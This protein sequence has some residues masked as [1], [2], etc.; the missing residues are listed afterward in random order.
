MPARCRTG[1]CGRLQLAAR[2][3]CNRKA[4]LATP[5]AAPLE[6]NWNCSSHVSLVFLN[7]AE[8]LCKTSLTSALTLTGNVKLNVLHF[9]DR[10]FK[11]LSLATYLKCLPKH[12]HVLLL[13]YKVLLIGVR[14]N[15][16]GKWEAVYTHTKKGRVWGVFRPRSN[17]RNLA[18]LCFISSLQS[19]MLRHAN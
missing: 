17:N 19:R 7:A 8:N 9:S 4:L 3:Y 15:K 2:A 1:D 18:G 10:N 6:R 16:L 5:L 12:R 13:P 11:K 14:H